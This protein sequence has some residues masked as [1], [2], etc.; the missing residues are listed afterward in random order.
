MAAEILDPVSGGV[1]GLGGGLIATFIAKWFVNKSE[2]E[3]AEIKKQLEENG[4]A[5]AVRDIAIAVLQASSV[6]VTKKLDKIES[7]I[8]ELLKK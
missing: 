1:G 7:K 3:I 4:K 6:E 5:D 2:R 8:D